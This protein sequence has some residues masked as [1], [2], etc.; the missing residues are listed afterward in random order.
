MEKPVG[1]I[2]RCLCAFHFSGR[3]EFMFYYKTDIF[4]HTCFMI[5]MTVI[6]FTIYIRKTLKWGPKYCLVRFKQEYFRFL[7]RVRIHWPLGELSNRWL[8]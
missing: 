4:G 7:A 1:T 2:M 5:S 8:H 6:W 3:V